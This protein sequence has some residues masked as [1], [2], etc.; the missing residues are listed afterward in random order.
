ME[1]WRHKISKCLT[2]AVYPDEI[3]EGKCENPLVC[4]SHNPV[5]KFKF[6]HKSFKSNVGGFLFSFDEIHGN[7]FVI[8]F[9]VMKINIYY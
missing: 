7:I 8:V 1:C 5:I 6:Y 3:D 2:I 9:D 4:L